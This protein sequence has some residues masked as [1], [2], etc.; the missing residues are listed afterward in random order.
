L[1]ISENTL[2]YITDG[3][4]GSGGK[5]EG[6]LFIFAFGVVG[7]GCDPTVIP[8]LRTAAML[9]GD[10]LY[11]ETVVVQPPSQTDTGRSLLHRSLP[12]P[13]LKT[14]VRQT[15]GRTDKRSE[16][17]YMMLKKLILFNQWFILKPQKGKQMFG[18]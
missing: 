14:P 15:D 9:C 10:G 5:G 7:E 18:Y 4:F 17:I 13:P 16:L 6:K 2:L 8:T 3:S 1:E 11:M 12:A